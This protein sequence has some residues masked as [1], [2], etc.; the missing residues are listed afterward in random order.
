MKEEIEDTIDLMEQAEDFRPI[1]QKGIKILKSYGPELDE[2]FDLL[3]SAVNRKR[4]Q[5]FKQLIKLEFTREEALA[6]MLDAQ[7]RMAQGIA[8]Y[9]TKR[10]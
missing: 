5:S 2:I 3:I 10:S 6:L 1:I 8:Q 4:A 7:T 9:N